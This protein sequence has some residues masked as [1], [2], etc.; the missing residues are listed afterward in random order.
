MIILRKNP[1]DLD[2]QNYLYLANQLENNDLVAQYVLDNNGILPA[3]PQIEIHPYLN[4]LPLQNYDKYIIGTFP[5]IS[6]LYY[7][8]NL[9]ELRQLNNR[10]ISRPGFSFFHGN[11][12]LLWDY[13]LNENELNNYPNDRLLIPSY[14]SNILTMSQINYSDIILK[15]QRALDNNR[16]KGSDNLLFNIIPNRNLV[17]H[18]LENSI[19]KFLM[20]NTASIYGMSGLN[21]HENGK[22]SLDKDAKSFDLFL[23]ILQEL[24]YSISLSFDEGINW[25]SLQNLNLEQRKIKFMF[26]MKII[27]D[28][29]SEFCKSFGPNIEKEFV[30]ITP[31]SPAVAQRVNILTGNPI[32]CNWRVNN[33]FQNTKAMLATIMSYFRNNNWQALQNMNVIF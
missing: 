27:N 8:H 12:G 9:N 24:D 11:K 31:F 21:F 32:V 17:L 3:E 26:K 16:Y 23:R 18:I 6:Y 5:P 22:V 13:F 28:K 30:V 19:A 33:N 10:N 2:D 14:L 7:S 20:F 29:S 4:T 15:T 1:M 25:I